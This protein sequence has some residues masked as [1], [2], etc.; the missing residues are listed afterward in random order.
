VIAAIAATA[1]G[2]FAAFAYKATL[3]QLK[4]ARE[5][6]KLAQ[7]QFKTERMRL[8]E[9]RRRAIRVARAQFERMSAEEE[10]TRPRFAFINGFQSS[11]LLMQYWD[12]KNI[13]SSAATEVS[14]TTADEKNLLFQANIVGAGMTVRF[15]TTLHILDQEG[16][17]FR[18]KT[19]FG[20]RWQLL[21][22]RNGTEEV[23]N[24]TRIYQPEAEAE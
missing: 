14:V 17:L 10:S 8:E 16:V 5:Q 23:R 6:L 24:V 11:A 21:V 4:L 19:E 7:E 2:I 1:A 12:A 18:F 3:T 20:S 13:G 15:Q 9:E 22:R